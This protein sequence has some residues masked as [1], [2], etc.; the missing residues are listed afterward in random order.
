MRVAFNPPT[1]REFGVLFSPQRGGS[2]GDI[3]VF[4]TPRMHQRGGGLFSIISGLVRKATPFLMK[5]VAP[6]ALNFGKNVISD[7]VSGEGN[8]KTSL[9]NRGRQALTGVGKEALRKIA[10]GGGRVGNKTRRAS[11]KNKKKRKAKTG[12]CSYNKND[13]FS[14]F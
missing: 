5:T 12:K 2:L 6:A 8:L 3:R 4:Q 10:R 9:R 14:L 11:T 7:V 13:V 1:V